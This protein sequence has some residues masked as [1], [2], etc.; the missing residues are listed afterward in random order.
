MLYTHDLSFTTTAWVNLIFYFGT[1]ITLGF[2]TREYYRIFWVDSV[3]NIY[4]F[5][6][7]RVKNL[8]ESLLSGLPI[9]GI[10][11]ELQTAMCCLCL[12]GYN[13]V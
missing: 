12:E 10:D 3:V 2:Y 6:K 13:D 5:L 8:N 1:G 7:K 9:I 11:R 4:R